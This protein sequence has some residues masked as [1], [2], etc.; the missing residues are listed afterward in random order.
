MSHDPILVLAVDDLEQ[1]LRLLDAVLSP[2]GYGVITAASGEEALEHLERHDIDL[3][4][5]DIMMPGID[6]YEVCRRIRAVPRW[7]FLPVVMIT[8][9]GD[10]EKRHALEAGADDFVSKPF[11]QAELIARV[12]SLARLKRYHDTIER[13][14][15]ELA[16][17]NV[18]LEARVASQVDELERVN[19][20]RRFL[21]RQ[22]VD[23]VLDHGDEAVL[24][25]HRRDIVVVF[26]DLRGFTPFAEASEPEEVMGVLS[27]YHAVL[28]ELIDR[29]EGT[30]ERFTGD[31]VMVFFN[32]PLPLEDPARRAIEMAIEIRDRVGDLTAAWHRRA[33]DLGIG[34]GVAQGYATLGRIGFEGRF[35]YA[36][37][38]SVTNLAARLCAA[39]AAGQILVAQRAFT[40]VEEH[41]AANPVG[42]L[43]VRGFSRAVR[44][45]AVDGIRHPENRVA[46]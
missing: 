12:A 17:W 26:C 36:A 16:R 30:L 25:S 46:P 19:R 2:R 43:D 3:V 44:A 8:A 10:Q 24:A 34:I 4:L 5:L 18:E 33:I 6:G 20:L 35:D 32:D 7:R 13:Q 11:D 41:I 45:Y 23:V 39:A 40:A 14:A 1:N 9:S 27:E 42:E 37:I 22:V 31:G 15:A 29:Y 38:G 21:S 28:G